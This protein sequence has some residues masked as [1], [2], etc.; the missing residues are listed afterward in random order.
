MRTRLGFAVTVWFLLLAGGCATT[1]EASTVDGAVKASNAFGF[2][3][4]RQTRAGQ[5]NFVGSPARAAIA[6]TMAAA[7]ARGETQSE[8]LHILHIDPGQADQTYGSFAAILTALNE[9][10]TDVACSAASHWPA[11]RA[12]AQ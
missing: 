1:F 5:E 11:E 10:N 4:Y 8:M 6:L 3:F 9:R 2:D 7:G 12:S